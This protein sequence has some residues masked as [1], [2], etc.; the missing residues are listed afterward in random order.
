MNEQKITPRN[1]LPEPKN[2]KT[3]EEIIKHQKMN[4][5]IL[6]LKKPVLFNKKALKNDI[7]VDLKSNQNVVNGNN[8]NTINTS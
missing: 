7:F 1:P 3:I 5:G 2:K 6:K 8:F 4:P